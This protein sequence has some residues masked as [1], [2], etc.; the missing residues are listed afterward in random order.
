MPASAVAVAS[1]AVSFNTVTMPLYS[2][3]E[4][5]LVQ[6]AQS[7]EA[8]LSLEHSS[9]SIA[10]VGILLSITFRD[11]AFKRGSSSNASND[12]SSSGGKHKAQV[13]VEHSLI[14]YTVHCDAVY[15]CQ[16]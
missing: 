3:R 12:S 16:R 6:L 10:V 4:A 7:G 15:A 2:V 1:A 11:A 14:Q 5:L 8:K 13:S 9:E